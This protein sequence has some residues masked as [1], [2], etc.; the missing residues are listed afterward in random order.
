MHHYNY[1]TIDYHDSAQ[2]NIA[3]AQAL[4]IALEHYPD[5][6]QILK[7]HQTIIHESHYHNQLR[8]LNLCWPT[9]LVN[10]SSFANS[11]RAILQLHYGTI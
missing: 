4:A 9:I 10:S 3:L 5:P 6:A 2:L 8:F 1:I 7:E 11:C